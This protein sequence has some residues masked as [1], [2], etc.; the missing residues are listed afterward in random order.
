L[1]LGTMIYAESK[2]KDDIRTHECNS[3]HECITL[4]FDKLFVDA[5]NHYKTTT[6]IRNA[7]W[8]N[9]RTFYDLFNLV[10]L[11][12][13]NENKKCS[14]GYEVINVIESNDSSM[15]LSHQIH[16][17]SW[18]RRQMVH[19]YN[20]WCNFLLYQP[21]LNINIRMESSDHLLWYSIFNYC[22][23]TLDYWVMVVGSL[24]NNYVTFTLKIRSNT[25]IHQQ[26]MTIHE[27]RNS[28]IT[29][30]NISF[31]KNTVTYDAMGRKRK[32]EYIFAM[33]IRGAYEYIYLTSHLAL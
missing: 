26:Y 32:P 27:N 28:E 19:R 8:R 7:K 22:Q 25:D 9:E 23:W 4:Y 29:K 17:H 24:H 12:S 20:K 5:T 10:M 2:L 18:R 14:N 21:L 1:C 3:V 30:T 33:A 15:T 16:W 13:I 31:T 6:A 11:Q